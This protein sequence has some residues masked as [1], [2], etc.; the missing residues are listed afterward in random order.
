MRSRPNTKKK[1]LSVGFFLATNKKIRKLEDWSATY[2]GV[3]H[4]HPPPPLRIIFAAAFGGEG[5]LRDY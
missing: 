5:A 4:H 2:D 1:Y 3:G